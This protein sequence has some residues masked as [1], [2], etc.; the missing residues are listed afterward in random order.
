MPPGLTAE[1]PCC[2]QAPLGLWSSQIQHP[3]PGP[4]GSSTMA[5]PELEHRDHFS[6]TEGSLQVSF[7]ITTCWC[8]S[9]VESAFLL[10][11]WPKAPLFNPPGL[12]LDKFMQN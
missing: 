10:L 8:K 12:A 2:T 5:T 7:P 11:C 6:S 4:P 3:V 1:V 9:S